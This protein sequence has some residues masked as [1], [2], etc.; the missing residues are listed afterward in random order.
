M[1]DLSQKFAQIEYMKVK[2]LFHSSRKIKEKRKHTIVVFI[3]EFVLVVRELL[4]SVCEVLDY[5]RP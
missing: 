5:I 4:R 2:K 3:V 1:L